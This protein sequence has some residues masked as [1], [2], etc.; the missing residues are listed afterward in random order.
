MA[1]GAGDGS[2]PDVQ[3]AVQLDVQAALRA[4]VERELDSLLARPLSAGLYLVAT[5]IG[6]LGDMSLRAVTTL[7]RV[8]R[9]YCEDT[10]HSLHLLEHYGLSRPL[11]PYHEHNGELVRP[12]ILAD[13]KRGARLALISD[14]GTPL[15][16][17]PGYKLV[18]A[19]LEA[20]RT[21]TA[22][23]GPSAVLTSL[24][25]SGLPS[26]CFHFAGFLP[27]KPG[28]RQNRLAALATIDATVIVFEAPTRVAASL[29]DIAAAMPGRTVALARELT[30]LHET[31]RRGTPAEIAEAIAADGGVKGECVLL[32]APP[33]RHAVVS[34][35]V[36]VA[37]LQQA[38]AREP[39]STAV[40]TVADV[41]GAPRKHVYNLALGLKSRRVPETSTGDTE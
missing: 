10:R 34:D 11:S 26:D 38:L 32:I 21:V 6:H 15:I 5:P 36:I 20:G 33:E 18:R 28:Q 23:P 19:A 35:D 3:P 9:I 13:L 12:R 29:A 22:L 4:A 2:D 7:A 1:A 17:D 41:L 14:A 37:Q 31:V 24:T 39:L 8:D 30:K 40:K 25:L 16:S 27:V